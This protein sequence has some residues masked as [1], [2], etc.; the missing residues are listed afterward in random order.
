MANLSMNE[1]AFDRAEYERAEQQFRLVKK[2]LP[3]QAVIAVA[4]EVVRRLA[5]R[6]PKNAQ[7]PSFPKP[8]EVE[9]LCDAL[10]SQ[11]NRA[12]DRII[13]EARQDGAEV[14]A[15]YL[16]YVAAAA[17]RLGD[18]WDADQIT[19]VDVTLA[20]GKLFRIIRGLRHI[21]A[22]SIIENRDE[23]PA[24]FAL[25]PGETHTLGIEIA[26]DLF[27]RN[28]WDIDMMVG[29]DHD[30]LLDRAEERNYR[31][32]VLV[33]SSDALIARLTRL[34]LALRISHPLSQIVVAG[35]IVEHHPDIGT[36]VGAD[37]VIKDIE[38][39]VARLK[40]VIT[41]KAT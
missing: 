5:F 27:R 10:L 32:I 15:I 24:M 40:D 18:L 39:A 1:Q 30:T 8:S 20:C 31:A 35:N 12:A 37:D 17:R 4:Q 22:P 25:V 21:I 28:G 7:T 23:R 9:R 34:V 2:E 19:F 14:E 33:A 11:D 13:L 36:L 26:A 6:M 41:E 16:G 3:E 29:M 38:T